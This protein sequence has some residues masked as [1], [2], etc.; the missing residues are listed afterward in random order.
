MNNFNWV[1]LELLAEHTMRERILASQQRALAANERRD[2]R[3]GV[4]RALASRLVRL[5]LR[6]DPAAGEGLGAFELPLAQRNGRQPA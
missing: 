2:G 5:G 6:L 4:K 3:S 1:I